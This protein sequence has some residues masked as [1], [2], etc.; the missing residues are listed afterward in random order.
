MA[1]YSTLLKTWGDT[2]SE[3][4]DG[5]SYLEGE[6]PVDAWDNFSKYNTV[7]DIQHLVSLTNSRIESD[8]GAAGSEPTSPE[9]S[10]LYHDTTNEALTYWDST[11]NSWRR[12]L[13][14]DGDTLE[15]AIDFSGYSADNVGSITGPTGTVIW[16]G[17]E[18]KSSVVQSLGLDAD[19][20]DGQH[21]SSLGSG[22]SDSGTQV[23]STATDFNFGSNLSVSD[24]GDGTV[25]IEAADGSDTH[26]AISE[27]GTQTLAS[28]D[29]ID[30]TGHLNVIDDGDGTVTIDPTHNHDSRYVNETDHD[31]AAHDAL[32]IDADTLDGNH[33]SAFALSGHTHDGRY[34]TE[35]ESD[36][37]FVRLDSGG[38][39]IPAYLTIGNVPTTLPEG[40]VVYVQD[41]EILYVEDGN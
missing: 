30:F 40:S 5:Y 24:D 22:A 3:Y 19:T 14:A 16:D 25:T 18:I 33:A 21:A 10:H 31:K 17:T 34:Y 20:V 6:Q 37:R 28:V 13:A 26:T 9:T 8:T 41:E 12:L 27:D 35:G 2:G 39:A 38:A 7:Q 4:P 11:A 1:N 23:L 36:N 15:G 29:D 32:N